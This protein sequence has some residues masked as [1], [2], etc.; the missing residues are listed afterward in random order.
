MS[1][2]S[3]NK[4]LISI[5][6]E[7]SAGQGIDITNHIIS[8]VESAVGEHY[9]A[10]PNI[11]IYDVDGQP[12]I[13]SKDWSSE[14]ADA[15]AN[16]YEQAIAQIPEPQD[17]SYLSGRIDANTSGINY[18]SSVCLTSHQDWTNTIKGASSYSYEQSTSYFD[19]WVEGQYTGDIT[20]ITNKITAISGNFD[21]YYKKTETS[22]KDEINDALQYV[23]ANAGKVYEGVSPIVVNN[24]EDKISADTWTFSAGSNVSFVDDN[25]NKITRIDVELPQPQDLSYISAQVDSANAGV[26]YLSGVVITAL[27]SD[28]ATTGDIAELAQSVSETYQTKG[29]YLVRSDS[30]NF[31]PANNPS[32]FIT[33][34]DLSN[35]YQKNETSGADE[36]AQAFN[37]IPHGDEEVNNVVH[38]YSSNGT[39]LIADDITGLQPKGDYYSASNIS[40][41]ITSSDISDL[42]SISLVEETSASIVDLIPSVEGLASESY[43]D[44]QVSGKADKNEIPDTSNFIT[45]ASAEE[46]YLTKNDASSTYQTIEGMTAYQPVGSYA[47]TYQL[48]NASSFLSGA[49]E[50]LD[51]SITTG[52]VGDLYNYNVKGLNLYGASS[53]SSFPS[54]GYV[55]TFTSNNA[56]HNS[57]A[58]DVFGLTTANMSQWNGK[59]YVSISSNGNTITGNYKCKV[60]YLFDGIMDKSW[61]SKNPFS[62]EVG[63]LDKDNLV[64]YNNYV[65]PSYFTNNGISNFNT[66]IVFSANDGGYHPFDVVLTFG[67]LGVT[68]T[69]TI[70]GIF[71]PSAI[72]LSN[73]YKK[74]ETSSKQEIKNA[75]EGLFN[76]FNGANQYV[77][78]NSGMI[79]FTVT[80]YLTSA[81]TFMDCYETVNANSGSWGG[82]P[83]VE[84]YVQTNSAQIDETVTSY[85]TNSGTFLTAHQAISA[86]EWNDCYDNVNTNSGAWGGDALPIT[87][88]DGIDLEIDNGTLYIGAS[89]LT[90]SIDYIETNSANIDEVVTNYQTASGTYLTAHQSLEGYVSESGFEYDGND[91]ITAY[92]GSAFAGQGGG[93]GGEVP[94]GTMNVSALEYN[95]VNEISGYNGSAIAQYGAEKQWL[96]HDDTLVHAA[97]SA[98]YALGCNIS[99]LQRLMGIDETVLFEGNALHNHATATLSEPFTNFEKIKVYG[100]TDDGVMYPWYTEVPTFSGIGF[101]GVATNNAGWSKWFGLSVPDSTHIVPYTG[102][103]AT[104]ASTTTGYLQNTWG[105]TRIIGIGRKQA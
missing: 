31:Y 14:I 46:T 72:D 49:I 36:L 12:T 32:G 21:D 91:L 61:N 97:N 5:G 34:I 11:D 24:T 53:T 29:D 7:Y 78:S 8:V 57:T 90:G 50:S 68:G 52:V 39:W 98:Q 27:P 92:N 30:A 103:V 17:L 13:S 77:Q 28:L 105:I 73:Y 38:T 56:S 76:Y 66:K 102:Y 95:A 33:G 42:A 80:S 84:N 75:V 79:D 65:K 55:P 94:T 81:G 23:S 47:T 26:D 20:N 2:L 9:S 40:G 71:I 10:G 44:E 101:I 82:N 87:G 15:S 35:Y 37:N 64:V 45:N 93:G 99:A 88:R 3:T 86:D 89:A 69:N 16:A 74:T 22:S 4:K 6:A 58:T 25:V 100:H 48:N 54:T 60:F 85:Q 41:F 59:P 83:E 104:W 96:V 51:E 19:N 67:D 1:I 18:I 63:I 43:V 70:S 62:G